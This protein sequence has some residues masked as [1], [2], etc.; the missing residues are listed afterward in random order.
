VIWRYSLKFFGRHFPH[1][2]ESLEEEYMLKHWLSRALFA[3]ALLAIAGS[4]ALAQNEPSKMVYTYVSE[5]AVPRNMWADMNKEN[6][7]THALFDKFLADGTITGYGEFVNLVHQ[8]GQPTHGSWFTSDSEAGIMKMLAALAAEPSSTSPVLTASKHW[9][10]YLQGDANERGHHSGT[11]TNAYLRVINFQVKPGMGDDFENAYK[12]YLK[13]YYDQQMAA[14]ALLSYGMDGENV[15]TRA[16][17][18]VSIFSIA[19]NA[20]A[21]DKDDAAFA[22]MM[23]KNPAVFPAITQS[24]PSASVRSTLALVTY[25]KEK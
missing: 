4:P 7:A 6:T 23:T 16:P 14:G 20:E 9:D 18:G 10:Y 8:E 2:T 15:Y 24:I 12:T 17:G 1:G 11:F 3:G 25:M 13:P 5:W 21:L 19:A 22:E